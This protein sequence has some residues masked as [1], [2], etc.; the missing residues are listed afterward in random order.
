MPNFNKLHTE[1]T[2]PNYV[3]VT[4]DL[5]TVPP[6]ARD[7]FV[8]GLELRDQ[9]REQHGEALEQIAKRA[10]IAVIHSSDPSEYPG[11]VTPAD[12]S[13]PYKSYKQTADFIGD[14][15]TKM[16][17][18]RVEVMSDI[19]LLVKIADQDTPNPDFAWLNT[20][21]V[22]GSDS[23]AQTPSLLEATGIPYIGHP[24]AAYAN[25]DHKVVADMSLNAND[26]PTPGSLNL[27]GFDADRL[28][29]LSQSLFRNAEI[30]PLVLIKPINGRGSVGAAVYAAF[31]HPD[32][33]GGFFDGSCSYRGDFHRGAHAGG[34]Q[35]VFR[36]AG[37]F[38]GEIF[39]GGARQ[40]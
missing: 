2:N 34:G 29:K 10:T 4:G 35:R 9:L 30:D 12:R 3:A 26:V 8:S 20:A 33:A 17:F 31:A 13:R 21:G 39:R 5:D 1:D 25:A 32:D 11:I 40:A 37:L 38:R 14:T 36:L 23:M 28:W 18:A 19:D 16:E 15:L 27:S 7:G 22:Q 6:D 24:P